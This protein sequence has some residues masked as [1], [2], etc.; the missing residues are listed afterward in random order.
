M[1]KSLQFMLNRREETYKIA[2]AEFHHPRD[3]TEAAADVCAKA[4]DAENPGGAGE[5]ALRKNI[6]MTITG[7]L[8]LNATPS[9]ARLVD[10]SLLQ[11]VQKELGIAA[12]K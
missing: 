8:K 3:V 6:D 9:L 4:I 11:E 10:F 7:P 1:V 2:Q 12:K 5:E